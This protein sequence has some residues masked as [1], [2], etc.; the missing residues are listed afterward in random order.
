MPGSTGQSRS[1]AIRR[2]SA[3][4]GDVVRRVA[5][6]DVDIDFR[7]EPG[8]ECGIVLAIGSRHVGW[9]LSEHL[10]ALE[11]NVAHLLD[12]VAEGGEVRC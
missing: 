10:D 7:E 12:T 4:V 6:R 3:L 8:L 11:D 1:D 2:A 5:E 9:T